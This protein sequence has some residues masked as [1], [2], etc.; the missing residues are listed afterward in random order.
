MILTNDKQLN[1]LLLDPKYEH[2][3]TYWVEVEGVPDSKDLKMLEEGVKI[4]LKGNTHKT[5]PAKARVLT[6]VEIE[7]REPPVNRVKHPVT[8][9]IE[10]RLTEGKNRQVRKMTAGV[11]HPTLRLIRVAI[12]DIKLFPMRPGEFTRIAR[13]PLYKKLQIYL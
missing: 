8:S 2:Q 4:N 9:W 5:A 10:I 13:K 12:E 6:E 7:E 3:K 1:H 11:G